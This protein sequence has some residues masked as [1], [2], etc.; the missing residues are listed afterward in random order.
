MKFT[1]EQVTMMGAYVAAALVSYGARPKPQNREEKLILIEGQMQRL[2]DFLL[3]N[4]CVDP[5]LFQNENISTETRAETRP[6]T[7]DFQPR[8]IV[9][10][11]RRRLD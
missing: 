11:M 2:F 9:A 10:M 1:R 6:A 8:D 4:G 3:D 7:S 5:S